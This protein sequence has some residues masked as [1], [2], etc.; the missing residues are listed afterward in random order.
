[1]SWKFGAMPAPSTP[2]LPESSL[3]WPFFR[4]IPG[5]SG[6]IA[7]IVEIRRRFC[8][9]LNQGSC[10]VNRRDVGKIDRFD[11]LVGNLFDGGDQPF[12]LFVLHGRYVTGGQHAL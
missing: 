3:V 12:A 8:L 5:N 4:A 6:E 11:E 9:E 2:M 7:K 10:G 1:M